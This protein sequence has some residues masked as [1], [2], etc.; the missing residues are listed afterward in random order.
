MHHGHSFSSFTRSSEVIS[1]KAFNQY[2]ARRFGVASNVK[3][4]RLLEHVQDR[5]GIDKRPILKVHGSALDS[6]AQ[7]ADAIRIAKTETPIILR[8]LV[9]TRSQPM[10][11]PQPVVK[12]DGFSVVVNL[13]T[14]FA[15]A[16]QRLQAM[17]DQLVRLDKATGTSDFVR[18][19]VVPVVES[20]VTK[21]D[22][23]ISARRP[24]HTAC[25]LLR[26]VASVGSKSNA[27]AINDMTQNANQAEEEPSEL[28][29]QATREPEELI[30]QATREQSM[31]DFRAIITEWKN[32]H[33]AGTFEQ[34]ICD[35][36]PENTYMTS[37]GTVG[38]DRRV[39]GATW[40]NEF[41]RLAGELCTT[42][43]MTT[44]VN[45]EC[46]LC[47]EEMLDLHRDEGLITPCRHHFH[48]SC[49]L[50]WIQ[51][52]APQVPSCPI[53]RR[54]ISAIRPFEH[55]PVIT[56]DDVV[57][58]QT[59]GSQPSASSAY[60]DEYADE[61]LA[62]KTSRRLVALLDAT[63]GETATASRVREYRARVGCGCRSHVELSHELLQ[64]SKMGFDD[65]S[66]QHA[67]LVAEGD[68][69]CA[70][71][72]LT[73]AWADGPLDDF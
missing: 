1:V 38:L 56:M 50:D 13:S 47:F 52:C 39:E 37:A 23:E 5:F 48:R 63:F 10:A 70:V 36:F 12:A 67:L 34:F 46:S 53:C 14:A 54:D 66:A 64:L 24:I 51:Q 6:D 19:S 72:I 9:E 21:I 25:L 30:A 31:R 11:R 3:L 29:A 68:V 20:A 33:A 8:V 58:C 42:G 60:A 16:T 69:A 65:V 28:T 2:Q 4:D 35:V 27:P 18:K 57:G 26:R 49:L 45:D 73:M 44:D 17:Q 32:E 71:E 40:R 62:T 15:A 43:S 59:I 61:H 22:E 41:D 7:L 55:V